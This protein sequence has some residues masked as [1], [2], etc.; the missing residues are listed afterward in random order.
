MTLCKESSRSLPPS[1][2][3]Y[4]K[5]LGDAVIAFQSQSPCKPPAGFQGQ[6]SRT[7][8]RGF[9]S[10]RLVIYKPS[11]PLSHLSVTC[12]SG[13]L[14][15]AYC[16]LLGCMFY[17]FCMSWSLI[18]DFSSLFFWSVCCFGLW[19]I[20]VHVCKSV[21]WSMQ[22]WWQIMPGVEDFDMLINPIQSAGNKQPSFVSS[23]F[24]I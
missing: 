7:R 4:E 21:Q 22:L 16:C 13:W 5:C 1:K 24:N 10:S 3:P 18:P 11:C 15:P 23:A 17:F 9:A 2:A 20:A 8:R 19:S 6:S 14:G 12:E